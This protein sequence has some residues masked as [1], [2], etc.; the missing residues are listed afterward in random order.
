MIDTF[1]EKA[2]ALHRQKNLSLGLKYAK[3]IILNKPNL[4]K[5]STALCCIRKP[6]FSS[7]KS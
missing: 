1:H 7:V 6:S 3:K 4:V 2:Y 5:T